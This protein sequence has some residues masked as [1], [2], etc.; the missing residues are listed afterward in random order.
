M[1]L[2]GLFS[3]PTARAGPSWV[4]GPT[5]NERGLMATLLVQLS[6]LYMPTSRSA[7]SNMLFRREM[8]I[9]CAP[10]VFSTM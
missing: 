7:S 4:K 1:A 9:N 5:T 3:F 8:T 10:W 2:C 6:V